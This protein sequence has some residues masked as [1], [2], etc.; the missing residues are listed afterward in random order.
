MT[1]NNTITAKQMMRFTFVCQTGVGVINLPALLAREAGH[2]GWISVA[3][4]GIIA[5]FLA[6]LIVVLLRRYSDKC[7]FDITRLIFGKIIGFIINTLLCIYFFLVASSG[8]MIFWI[9]LK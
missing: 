5:I 7:I 6:S 8:L 2:D 1:E 4:S 9:I 3:V